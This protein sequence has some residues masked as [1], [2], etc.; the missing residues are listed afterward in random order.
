[1][2]LS[3]TNVLEYVDWVHSCRTIVSCDGLGLHLALALGK[4]VVALLGARAAETV[5][6]YGLGT[7]VTPADGS[8]EVACIAPRDVAAAVH[9]APALRAAG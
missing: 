2:P 5:P 3:T 6:L 9:R 1:M 4:R 7:A 8:E